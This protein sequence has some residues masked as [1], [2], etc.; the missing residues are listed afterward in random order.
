M[1]V[2]RPS[3]ARTTVAIHACDGRRTLLPQL[4]NVIVSLVSCWENGLSKQAFAEIAHGIPYR[5]P[6]GKD[7]GEEDNQHVEIMN[8]DGIG[9]DN[10]AAVGIA[11][12]DEAEL[13]LQQA[14]QQACTDAQQSAENAD[15]AAFEEEDTRY[16]VVGCTQIAERCN[17]ITLVDDEHRERAYN[18]KAGHNED[19]REEDIGHELF[20]LHNLERV[21]L[22]LIAV[23]YGKTGSG[24]LLYLALGC[25]E[26]G[27]RFQA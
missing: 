16:L 20:N 23:F 1:K 7:D 12:P 21:G 19:E 26:I 22:L 25:V 5:K 14:Q 24:N 27:I 10:V 11:H 4:P 2:W 15:H 8:A 9:V 3:Y 6:S 18:V 17:V 13:L